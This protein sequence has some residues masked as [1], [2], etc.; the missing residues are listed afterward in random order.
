MIFFGIF[1]KIKTS[2]ACI[3]ELTRTYTNTRDGL[4]LFI[5]LGSFISGRRLRFRR[6]FPSFLLKSSHVLFSAGE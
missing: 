6:S 2:F 3:N 4:L 1:F 5:A